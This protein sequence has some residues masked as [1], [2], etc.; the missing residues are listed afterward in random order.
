LRNIVWYP[1]SF[2]KAK[3]TSAFH[4]V[5]ITD[6]WDVVLCGDDVQPLAGE[7]SGARALVSSSQE[8]PKRT[9]FRDI[10]GDSAL[11]SA[12]VRPIVQRD[13]VGNPKHWNSKEIANVF[14]GPAYL[15]PTL[16][17]LFDSLMSHFLTLRP[18]EDA[19]YPAPDLPGDGNDSSMDIDEPTDGPLVGVPRHERVVDAQEMDSFIGLFQQYG[20]KGGRHDFQFMSRSNTPA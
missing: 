6:S 15:I 9:L 12:P 14:D 10:F 20:L 8:P 4:V 11:T 16:D 7:G 19:D 2:S 18:S 3:V 1:Q 5:G 17:T 13:A